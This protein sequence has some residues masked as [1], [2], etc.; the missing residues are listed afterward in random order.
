MLPFVAYHYFLAENYLSYADSE[1]DLGVHINTNFSFTDHCEKFLTS[2]NQK[3]GILKRTCSFVKDQ[4]RRRVLYLSLVRSQFE[5]CSPVWRPSSAT[6]RDKF[7]NFQKKCI[8]WILH[9]SNLSYSNEVYLR[10]CKQLNILPLSYRFD[11]NDVILFYKIIHSLI[12]VNMPNYLTL[13]NGN[14]RLRSTH[15]DKLSF[16]CSLATSTA[17]NRTLNKSFFFRSHLL[18]N[19]LPFDTRNSSTLS[20]FKHRL[21]QHFRLLTVPEQSESD[22]E[23]SF[24]SSDENSNTI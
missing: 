21:Y 2:A 23:W 11:T 7:E 5:H 8:K 14:S 17:G 13:F 9:E 12:P 16:V 15:L 6:M 22:E 3:F 24:L 1:K 4:K 10:K 20:E 19:T 18:W